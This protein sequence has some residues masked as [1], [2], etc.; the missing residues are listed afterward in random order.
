[1]RK[2]LAMILAGGRGDELSVLTQMRPKAAVPFGGLYRV[3]DFPMSNLMHSGIENV[4][5]LSQYR[6][7][8]LINHIGNGASWEMVGRDRSVTILPPFKRERESS[9]YRGGADA[10]LQNL[11][12]LRVHQPDLVL[13][14]SG[15]HVYSMNY[16]PLIE[17][18]LEH[19]AEVTVVFARCDPGQAWRFG[20]ARL[21]SAGPGRGSRVLEYIEKPKTAPAWPG[22]NIWASL[23]IYLFTPQVLVEVLQQFVNTNYTT[24]EFGR[25]LLPEMVNRYRVF[26]Y[27]NDGYWGYTRTIDEYWQ[28]SMDM[29]GERPPIDPEHWQVRTN[30]EHE[31]VRDRPPAVIAPG[32]EIVNSLIANGCRVSGR[33]RNSILFPGV[34]VSEGSEIE[35]SI[36]IFDAKVAAGCRLRKVI[37]DAATVIASGCVI[38]DGNPT[39]PNEE[40]S[41]LLRSGITLIG[42]GAQLAPGLQIGANCIVHPNLTPE[43]F[44]RREYESGVSIR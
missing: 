6:S 11:G 32:A 22:D 17:F 15:D 40:Y 5:I 29:L 23:T 26:G 10:V 21:E 27:R 39:I 28:T 4:G 14:L 12:F 2:I 18:H 7:Y 31:A 38:G 41:E 35:D 34:E 13:V 24:L 20:V 42:R 37:A 30:L 16:R 9:W 19:E 44:S 36:L 33:V 25:D 43:S 8:S 3:I 1:M